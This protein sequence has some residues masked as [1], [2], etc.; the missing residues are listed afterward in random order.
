[1]KQMVVPM[2]LLVAICLLG[3][4]AARADGPE[5]IRARLESAVEDGEIP[6]AVVAV[7]H[8]G[9]VVFEEAFGYADMETGRKHRVDSIFPL[10]S[11]SKPIMMTALCSMV[12]L[13]YM[14]LD[15]PVSR[16]FPVYRQAA[17]EHGT[18]V[19]S[20]TLRGIMSCTSGIFTHENRVEKN[21]LIRQWHLLRFPW[22]HRQV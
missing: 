5:A 9:E 10:G 18:P 13:G 15:E 6:G 21:Y 2:Y 16:W 22:E 12:D 14:T 11:S 19:P 7:I 8:R 17:L 4:G 1:M 20:P 3:A